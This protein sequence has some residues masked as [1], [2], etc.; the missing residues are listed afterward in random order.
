MANGTNS[1]RAAPF[2]GT[3]GKSAALVR[4]AYLN[5]QEYGRQIEEADG[6]PSKMPPRDLGNEVLLEVLNG[7]RVVHH[8]TH[9]HD[10]ILT[11]LRLQAEFGFELVLQHVSDGWKVAEQIAAAG[12]P[13]SIILLDSPGGKEEALG[14]NWKTG[15][16][17]E[18]AG[19]PVALHT[20]DPI[21]DSRYF[22]RCAG[23]AVRGGMSREGALSAVTLTAAQMLGLGDS[24]GS[25]EAGKDADFIVL[26]GDPLS[27]YTHV[28][29]T[30]IEGEKVFDLAD[31][32][33][34]LWAEGGYGASQPQ[35]FT[36]CCHGEDN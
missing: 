24:I 34:R 35:A 1:Q 2:P 10:D 19:V 26:D 32:E 22:L 28:H 14:L 9:R 8:H 27:V 31:D 25:L 30:W 13:C 5:A 23:F 18:Q 21:N 3:R 11:V 20:D 7:D 12:V 36:W 4:Q 16:I 6:D 33:D 15:A 17:L 29:E